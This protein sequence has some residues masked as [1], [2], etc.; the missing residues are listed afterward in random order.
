[1]F[2]GTGKGRGTHKFLASP[3]ERSVAEVASFLKHQHLYLKVQAAAFRFWRLERERIE[4]KIKL[5][6][7][8]RNHYLLVSLS[9]AA[10][11]P[12]KTSMVGSILSALFP[13]NQGR[14]A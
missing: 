14:R 5:L 10:P 9:L 8:F 12:H 1:M 13:V 11:L 3:G 7:P 4:I 6:A 2:K